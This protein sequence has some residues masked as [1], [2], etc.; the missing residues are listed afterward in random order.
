MDFASPTVHFFEATTLRVACFDSWL[1][2]EVEMNRLAAFAATARASLANRLESA[3]RA[4][5]PLR[6]LV[7]ELLEVGID[8]AL[9]LQE[10]VHGDGSVQGSMTVLAFHEPGI[11]GT[12]V[13]DLDIN[14]SLGSILVS[15][16]VP[17]PDE[18]PEAFA[19][20]ERPRPAWEDEFRT[21]EGGYGKRSIDDIVRLVDEAFVARSLAPPQGPRP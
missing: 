1:A 15:T 3:E 12:A 10:P 6:Q 14:V 21:V 7:D 18:D 5:A 19:L 9:E 4:V 20:G 11:E 8:A 13:Y 2:E 16:H 17:T